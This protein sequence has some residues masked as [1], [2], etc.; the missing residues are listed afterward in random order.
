MKYHVDRPTPSNAMQPSHLLVLDILV[1]C[2]SDG[3]GKWHQLPRS[4]HLILSIR[5]RVVDGGTCC[6]EWCASFACTPL[7]T[8][9]YTRCLYRI[10]RSRSPSLESGESESANDLQRVGQQVP[11]PDPLS[12]RG[13]SHRR[14]PCLVSVKCGMTSASQR[15]SSLWI[16]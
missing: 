9:S 4:F 11:V 13:M 7:L 1:P 16:I 10:S 12:P 6:E 5:L 2:V 15:R 14:Q 8:L 3:R